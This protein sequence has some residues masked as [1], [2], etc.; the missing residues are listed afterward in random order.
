M[1]PQKKYVDADT[2]PV[3][4]LAIVYSASKLAQA[5]GDIAKLMVY[6]F[7]FQ[8][9]TQPHMAPVPRAIVMI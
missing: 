4:T 1:I 2:E 7:N 8:K 9:D 6:F 3:F 5:L